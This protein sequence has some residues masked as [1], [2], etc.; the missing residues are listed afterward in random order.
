MSFP[1]GMRPERVVFATNTGTITLSVGGDAARFFINTIFI[2][3]DTLV[4]ALTL[5]VTDTTTLERFK[6]VDGAVGGN[7]MPLGNGIACGTGE[8]VTITATGATTLTGY[9]AVTFTRTSGSG[10]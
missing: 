4:G 2:Q 10:V 8:D 1:H 5:T 6:D 9:M 7:T 3:A